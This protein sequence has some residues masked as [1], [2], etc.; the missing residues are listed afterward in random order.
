MDWFSCYVLSWD[1]SNSLDSYFCLWK[2]DKAFLKGKPE[3]FN[4]DQGSQVT[5][6]AFT[7]RLLTS[8]IK[9]IWCGRG[10]AMDNNLTLVRVTTSDYG[11]V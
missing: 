6:E 2:L 4:S 1:I 11:V 10:R 8:G 3:I 5:N 9:I 7:D